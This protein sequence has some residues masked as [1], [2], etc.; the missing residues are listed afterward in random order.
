[1]AE[2]KRLKVADA[3]KELGMCPDLLRRAIKHKAIPIGHCVEGSKGRDTYII[4]QHE[5]E[6]FK[7]GE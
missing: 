1:M 3:A 2:F 6:Q 5:L 4:Y 7:K